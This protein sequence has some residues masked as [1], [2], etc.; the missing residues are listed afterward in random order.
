MQQPT[1]DQPAEI[2]RHT[3]R[4]RAVA[5]EKSYLDVAVKGSLREPAH[6]SKPFS[7]TRKTFLKNHA[8]E[9]AAIDFLV[10]PRL[11]F[12]LLYVFIVMRHERREIAHVNVTRF[13]SAA[14]TAQ[15]MV[16]AFLLDTTPCYVIRDQDGI[17][18]S[19]SGS[20]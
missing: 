19:S 10:L 8:S 20:V 16:E 14:W 18:G 15:Q 7:Q 13:P 5:N 4:E 3:C 1:I 11:T 2:A 9:M 6:P 12:R 17:Y